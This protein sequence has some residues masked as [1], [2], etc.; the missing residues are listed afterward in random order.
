[1]SVFQAI[2]KQKSSHSNSG[3]VSTQHISD[4]YGNKESLQKPVISNVAFN[5]ANV[6]TKLEVSQ[7]DDIYE[8]EADRI[9]DKIVKMPDLS[10]SYLPINTSTGESMTR[11]CLTCREKEDEVIHRKT[12]INDRCE[13]SADAIDKVRGGFPLDVSTRTFMESRFG[14]DF[15]KVVIH[16]DEGSAR[17]ANAVHA[18]AYTIGNNIVFGKGQYSPNTAGGRNL[19]A[20]ELTHVLQQ[21]GFINARDSIGQS[22]IDR[23]DMINEVH[24]HRISKKDPPQHIPLYDVTRYQIPLPPP[25]F[26]LV[27]AMA[28]VDN[29]KTQTPQKL[30]SGQVKGVMPGSTEEIFLWYILAQISTVAESGT[31]ADI[32]TAIGWPPKPGDPA[33]QGKVTVTISSQ[34]DGIAELISAGPITA[35]SR[36]TTRETAVKELQSKYGI[37]SVEDADSKWTV[38]ELN[39]IIGAFDLLA[40]GDRAALN[41]VLL[42]RVSALQ[43]GL[44]GEFSSS[45]GSVGTPAPAPTAGTGV[46]GGGTPTGPTQAPVATPAPAAPS[47]K[48]KLKI[49]DCAFVGDISGFVGGK[50][51]QH[52]K[53]FQTIIHEVGHAVAS[54]EFLD[55]ESQL[56]QAIEQSNKAVQELNVSVRAT[57]EIINQTN[58]LVKEEQEMLGELRALR[59]KLK[60]AQRTKDKDAILAAQINIVE[61]SATVLVKRRELDAKRRELDAKRTLSEREQAAKRTTSD[62]ARALAQTRKE[63]AG[64]AQDRRVTHFVDFV[65][66]NQIKP[67]TKYARDNWLDKPGEFFAEAYSLWVTDPEFLK[68][69]FKVLSD[70]FDAKNYLK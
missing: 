66:K 70:W 35:P 18:L 27:Q 48:S 46:S 59:E 44:C 28:R 40:P 23:L 10:E 15:S 49:A 42:V 25:Q 22:S 52:P 31:E 14:Y 47:S 3:E 53:S 9:A 69:N 34:G 58:Q 24:T 6:Q 19:L 20:H 41:G 55:L 64:K 50:A 39:K 36:T 60:A 61:G 67:F 29:L 4:Y 17:S 7:P 21:S 30:K 32:L 63:L 12:D 37:A 43:D 51:I 26:T 1:L 68:A 57:N 13:I 2:K 5:F 38:E 54:K 65:N 33:P 8:R 45:W 56:S 62:A 11:K 16:N